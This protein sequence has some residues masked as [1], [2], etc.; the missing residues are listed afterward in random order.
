MKIQTIPESFDGRPVQ[1]VLFGGEKWM[2]GPQIAEALGFADPVDAAKKMYQRNQAEFDE[3]SCIAVELPTPA[4][5]R[6]TRIYNARGAALFAMKAQTPK[7]EAFRRWV[8]DVL[9]GVASM[10]EQGMVRGFSPVVLGNLREMFLA[11]PKMHSLVR[12]CA[13]E[14]GT[15]EIAKLLETTVSYVNKNRRTAEA[16][17]LALPP[18]SLAKMQQQP[19]FLKLA[20][21]RDRA[22]QKKLHQQLLL[23][24]SK[25]DSGNA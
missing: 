5:R 20:A 11:K 9:E 3:S 19:Q 14:L 6:L 18:A 8:L 25:E 4:G 23:A 22:S 13:M 16:L 12:Y 7:G 10:P 2:K 17:G 1:V 21:M 15:A 24:A